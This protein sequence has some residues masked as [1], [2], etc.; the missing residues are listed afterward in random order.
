MKTVQPNCRVRLRFEDEEVSYFVKNPSV[1]GV[2]LSSISTTSP[3]GKAIV[4]KTEGEEVILNNQG[5][6]IWCR[7]VKIYDPAYNAR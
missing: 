6:R 2:E 4:G 1:S 3:L 5:L 7:I